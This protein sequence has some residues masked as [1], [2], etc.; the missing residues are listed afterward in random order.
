MPKM[1]DLKKILATCDSRPI[2]VRDRAILLIGFAGAFRRSEIVGLDVKH[3]AWGNDRL[4]ITARN[5]VRIAHVSPALIARHQL[6]SPPPNECVVSRDH[7]AA[8]DGLASVCA[9]RLTYMA[10]PAG[11]TCRPRPL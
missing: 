2:G 8:S 3:L 4:T 11:Y 6:V 7:A 9:R 10:H 1:H 5:S